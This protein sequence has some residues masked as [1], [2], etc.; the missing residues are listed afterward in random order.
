VRGCKLIK[1]CLV[2]WFYISVATQMGYRILFANGQSPDIRGE[3]I[4]EPIGE[5]KREILKVS[6][7]LMVFANGPS[8][9]TNPMIMSMK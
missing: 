1:I 2:N 5:L 3:P 6:E 4:G 8:P 9:D 7:Y